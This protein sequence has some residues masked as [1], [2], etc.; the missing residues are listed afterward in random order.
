[1]SS[2]KVSNSMS[3]CYTS[4]YEHLEERSAEFSGITSIKL[5]SRFPI[6]LAV[7]STTNMKE[8][9]LQK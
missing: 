8:K 1:M 3:P 5:I 9:V 7:I 4:G 6:F 2:L